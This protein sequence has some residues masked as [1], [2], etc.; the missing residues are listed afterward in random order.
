MKK[1]ALLTLAAAL[2]L[3]FTASAAQAECDYEHPTKAKLVKSNCAQA[4]VS[5]GNPGGNTPNDSTEGGVPTCNPPESF[6]EASGNCPGTGWIWN[7]KSSQGQVQFKANK[8][9]VISPLNPPGA[10]DLDV[11]LKLKGVDTS[12]GPASGP[13]TLATVARAT[14]NDRGPNGVEGSSNTCIGGANA[15]APCA[16]ASVCPGGACDSSVCVGGGNA[17][18]LCTAASECPGGTCDSDDESMTVID[19]PAGFP[20]NLVG[21]KVTLKTS[22]NALLNNIGQPGL[23]GCSNIEVVSVTIVDSNGDTFANL[24]TFLTDAIKP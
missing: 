15:G 6:C 24:G 22:A 21:G 8:N 5:C 18:A 9:K 19:F 10:Q 4:M 12:G 14:L 23:P 1:H 13:G 2:A 16:A 7:D 3:G 20:F 11:K 17:G